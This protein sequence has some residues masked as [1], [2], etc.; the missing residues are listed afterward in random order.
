MGAAIGEPQRKE[1]EYPMSLSNLLRRYYLLF[2]LIVMGSF[3]FLSSCR[4]DSSGNPKVPRG[5]RSSGG[6]HALIETS[7]GIVE[8][9]LFER[10]APRAVEN[11]R[12]LAQYGYYNGLTF[13]RIVKGFMIQGGDP[14]GD[15]SGGE[16]AWG[17]TFEDEINPASPLYQRGY[18]RGIVAMANSGPNTNGSQFFIMHQDYSLP[19]SY[20]IF[21]S[22]VG[23]MEVVDALGQTPTTLGADGNMSKPLSRVLIN[24]ISLQP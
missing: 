10:E 6:L 7:Q 22:V 18:R 19:P 21:G 17:G 12:L 11:F 3:V 15:G 23:G 14:N 5:A 13:H 1:T 2:L 9:E 24:K 16:S 8:I 4:K 20:V